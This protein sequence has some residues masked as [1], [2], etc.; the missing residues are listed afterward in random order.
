MVRFRLLL[1]SQLLPL[2]VVRLEA[3][4]ETLEGERVDFR[5]VLVAEP[6]HLGLA[7]PAGHSLQQFA[8][9]RGEAAVGAPDDLAHLEPLGRRR[10][11][12]RWRGRLHGSICKRR[13]L[14]PCQKTYRVYLI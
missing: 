12:R 13:S 6:A 14:N 9:P 11:R 4:R 3:V 10:C 1:L 7:V 2:P 8:R 5:D